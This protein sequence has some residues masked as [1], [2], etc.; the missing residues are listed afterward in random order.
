MK[1]GVAGLGSIGRATAAYLTLRGH[2][3]FAWDALEE[4]QA[5]MEETGG[6][7]H[8]S[9]AL[10][11]NPPSVHKFCRTI[12]EL[13]EEARLIIICVPALYHYDI[14]REMAPLLRDHVVLLHP[15][16]TMG[17]V[18]FRNAISSYAPAPEACVIMES[19]STLFV[20]RIVDGGRRVK[21][22]AVKNMLKVAAFPSTQTNDG[23]ARLSELF[24]GIHIHREPSVLKT[25]FDNPNPMVHPAI[26]LF[27]LPRID[28]KEPF[29]FYR[30]GVTES[31]AGIIEVMDLERGAVMSAFGVSTTP[32]IQWFEDVYGRRYDS[33]YDVFQKNPAYGE[34]M[35]PEAPDHRFLT[36]DIS[37]GLVPL[38]GF[39]ERLGVRTAVIDSIINL[40]SEVVGRDLRASGRTLA[41]LGLDGRDGEELIRMFS[42][43]E[44]SR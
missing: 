4:V 44:G 24:E 23:A 5:L 42:A 38:V 27:N 16:S 31:V 8:V 11:E 2:E 25:S 33:V 28:R 19:Q 15:G 39:G 21:I 7:I 36:E 40:S 37:M 10:G 32:L 3:V 13:L 1:V 43:E 17:A 14:A 9:G 29:F 20:A 12:P 26:T 30:E 34:I 18:D 6:A 35:G 22:P 41:H